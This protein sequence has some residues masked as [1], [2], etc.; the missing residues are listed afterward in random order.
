[1]NAAIASFARGYAGRMAQHAKSIAAS[2]DA[3]TSADLEG[4]AGVSAVMV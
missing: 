1:M 4:A 3:Y 2:G